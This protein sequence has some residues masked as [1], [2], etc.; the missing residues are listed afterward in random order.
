MLGQM[1][2]NKLLPIPRAF[3]SG[4]NCYLHSDIADSKIFGKIGDQFRNMR[5]SDMSEE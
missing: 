3:N 4:T 2:F 5:S 1:E